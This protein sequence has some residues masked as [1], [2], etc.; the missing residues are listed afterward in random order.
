MM[1]FLSKKLLFNLKVKEFD[2][3]FSDFPTISGATT[4]TGGSTI[5]DVSLGWVRHI[6]TRGLR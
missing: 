6:S 4:K 1:G 2:D 5:S 3:T